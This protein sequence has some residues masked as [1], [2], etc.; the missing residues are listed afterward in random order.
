MFEGVLGGTTT[1]DFAIDDVSVNF[2]P[3]ASPAACDFESGS[4]LWSNRMTDD[5]DWQIK[6]GDS[7]LNSGPRNDHTLKNK[8]GQSIVSL[9]GN[10]G[11]STSD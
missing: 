8:L 2:G 3:C 5:F 10:F 1:S 9:F 4:C 6:Q 7:F 11:K